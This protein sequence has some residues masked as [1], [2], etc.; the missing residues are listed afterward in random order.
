MAVD[1]TPEEA[2]Y[3]IHEE[4]QTKKKHAKDTILWLLSVI[5]KMKRSAGE[6]LGAG[7]RA[8]VGQYDLRQPASKPPRNTPPP[9]PQGKNHTGTTESTFEVSGHQVGSQHGGGQIKRSLK[10]GGGWA[11][12]SVKLSLHLVDACA[13]PPEEPLLKRAVRVTDLGAVSSVLNATEWKSIWGL[14]WDPVLTMG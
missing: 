13:R 3:W 1:L 11:G 6:A 9:P 7:P 2:G 14:I 4:M 5:V 12:G 8:E 10:L